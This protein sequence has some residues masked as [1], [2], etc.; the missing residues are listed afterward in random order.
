MDRLVDGSGNA[1]FNVDSNT[2]TITTNLTNVNDNAPVL[3]VDNA[4]VSLAENA[5]ISAVV[6]ITTLGID[7]DTSHTITVNATSSNC[8]EVTADFTINVGS[9]NDNP[10]LPSDSNATA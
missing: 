2:G 1:L 8:S 5:A 9:V 10:V 6:G 3:T 4:S 7:A